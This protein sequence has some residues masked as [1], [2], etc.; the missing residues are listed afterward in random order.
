MILNTD[1]LRGLQKLA[2]GAI[3]TGFDGMPYAIFS[4]FL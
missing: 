3:V 4:F 1:T 2:S